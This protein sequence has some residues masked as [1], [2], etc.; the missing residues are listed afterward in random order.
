VSPAK[1]RYGEPPHL[2]RTRAR[3][4]EHESKRDEDFLRG[5]HGEPGHLGVL[6]RR[7]GDVR[8]VRSEVRARRGKHG[9]QAENGISF[10][11][12][13]FASAAGPESRDATGDETR[14]RLV[15]TRGPPIRLSS[16]RSSAS[17]PGTDPRALPPTPLYPTGSRSI[18]SANAVV[19]KHER[20]AFS[21]NARPMCD[22]CQVRLT[23][24]RRNTRAARRWMA[25]RGARA[26]ARR[27]RRGRR[28]VA[29]DSEFEAR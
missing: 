7:R 6:R 16:A 23:A 13:R 9:E 29:T 18:H 1:A 12:S 17:R 4:D 8:V 26:V 11:S 21:A 3:R 22:I 10:L 15:S 28:R 2:L 27:A 20:V 24:T 14:G 19:A 25:R 5:V